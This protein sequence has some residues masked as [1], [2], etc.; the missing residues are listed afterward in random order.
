MV[1]KIGIHHISRPPCCHRSI[2]I[3]IP[4]DRD[5][6]AIACPGHLYMSWLRPSIFCS[7]IDDGLLERCT[8]RV[9]TR[10]NTTTTSS[11]QP[12]LDRQAGTLI[13]VWQV[14]ESPFCPL[15]IPRCH[16]LKT[17]PLSSPSSFFFFFRSVSTER[18]PSTGRRLVPLRWPYN[19][20][21]SLCNLPACVSWWRGV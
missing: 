18:A 16:E 19:A 15:W 14:L 2:S 21:D 7:S 12:C 13:W 10:D 4:I 20:G 6:T 5:T 17:S 1:S 9:I 8:C 11:T 3:S